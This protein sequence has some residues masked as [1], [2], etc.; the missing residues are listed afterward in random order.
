MQGPDLFGFKEEGILTIDGLL[1]TGD[2]LIAQCPSWSWE[3]GKP[4]KRILLLPSEKQFLITKN[5]PCLRRASSKKD[6]ADDE[7]SGERI[8]MC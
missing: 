2:H 5:V 4:S 8:P 1:I 7:C 6:E 3:S